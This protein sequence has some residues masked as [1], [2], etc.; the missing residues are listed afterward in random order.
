MDDQVGKVLDALNDSKFAENTM[1]VFT[2]D[3]GWNFGEKDYL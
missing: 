2:A 3:R 1:V